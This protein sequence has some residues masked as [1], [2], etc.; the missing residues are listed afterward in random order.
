MVK[1]V[2]FEWSLVIFIKDSY[3]FVGTRPKQSALVDI[4][5]SR[6]RFLVK[7]KLGLMKDSKKVGM[8]TEDRLTRFIC[9]YQWILL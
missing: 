2:I 3:S 6:S 9:A 4:N 8:S 1:Y 7:Y 5:P